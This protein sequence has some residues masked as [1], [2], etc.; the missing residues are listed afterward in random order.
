MDN[1]VVYNGVVQ[2]PGTTF[3]GIGGIATYQ[4]TGTV[5]HDVQKRRMT[6]DDEYPV[7]VNLASRI[8]M[9]LLTR[10]LALEERKVADI[11]N[12]AQDQLKTTSTNE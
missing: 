6:Q 3:T 9:L 11:V 8:V 7:S 12:D 5:K 1:Q 10:E 2:A 4:G